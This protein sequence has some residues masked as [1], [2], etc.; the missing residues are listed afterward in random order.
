MKKW[1]LLLSCITAS[2]SAVESMQSLEAVPAQ[3]EKTSPLDEGA[4]ATQAV[5]VPEVSAPEQAAPARDEE[6]GGFLDDDI[7]DMQALFKQFGFSPEQINAMNK[8]M[9]EMQEKAE[10]RSSRIKELEEQQKT[11]IGTMSNLS[12]GALNQDKD[13]KELRNL[14]KKKSELEAELTK[15]KEEEGAFMPSEDDFKGLEKQ[16]EASLPHAE[17]GAESLGEEPVEEGDAEEQSSEEQ[18]SA[19]A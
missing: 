15:L 8:E 19:A 4:E 5:V 1:L 14:E 12:Q 18:A 6:T 10:K 2:V 9:K 7:S 17:E 3:T 13:N 16:F 11:L